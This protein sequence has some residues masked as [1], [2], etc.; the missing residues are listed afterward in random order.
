MLAPPLWTCTPCHSGVATHCIF[1][2]YSLFGLIYL[3]ITIIIICALAICWCQRPLANRIR[4]DWCNFRRTTWNSQEECSQHSTVSNCIT[5]IASL[6]WFQHVSIAFTYS[7]HANAQMRFPIDSLLLSG[8]VL[9]SSVSKCR[10]FQI[11]RIE[12][13]KILRSFCIKRWSGYRSWALWPKYQRI[14]WNTREREPVWTHE[15]PRKHIRNH[16]SED[17]CRASEE[18]NQKHPMVENT[19]QKSELITNYKSNWSKWIKRL[20]LHFSNHFRLL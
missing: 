3:K 13:V 15:Q 2:M 14:N 1:S 9:A 7:Q 6:L 17:T 4:E 20:K 10:P 19:A 18:E 11:R 16:W 12:L 8:G 5:A